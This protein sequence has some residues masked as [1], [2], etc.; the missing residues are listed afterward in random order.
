M[1]NDQITPLQAIR[2]KAHAFA[3]ERNFLPFHNIKDL[4]MNLACEVAE[5][6][7]LMLW[8]SPDELKARLLQDSAFK[9]AVF[10]EIGDVMHALAELANRIEGCDLT[11]V[12]FEKMRKTEAKYDPAS[13]YGK[14]EKR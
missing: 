5:L 2:D 4:T 8:K 13:C 11:T 6:Q 10:D 1:N 12:F 14:G 9:E 7:E 3:Q